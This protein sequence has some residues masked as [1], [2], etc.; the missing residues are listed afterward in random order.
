[1]VSGGDFLPPAGDRLYGTAEPGAVSF[2]ND[3]W[4]DG[5]YTIIER[6]GD[7]TL[8]VGT[9]GEVF[10]VT[11]SAGGFSATISA[12]SAYGNPGLSRIVQTG[13]P[14][15]GEVAVSSIDRLSAL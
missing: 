12:M 3:P 11:P 1:L 9:M 10:T 14:F 8:F 15:T 6:V 7:I 5:Y 13:A 4:G 2:T